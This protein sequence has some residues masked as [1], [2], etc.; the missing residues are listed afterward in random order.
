VSAEL[1]EVV[2]EL[3]R[4]LR[5]VVLPAL[6]A[7]AGRAH[8]GGG[9][10]AGDVTFAIDERAEAEVERTVAERAPHVA[11]Y[12]EDRGLTMPSGRAPEHVLIVDPIDGTRP[13]M[14]GFEAACVSVAVAPFGDGAPTM[15]DVELGVVVEIKSGAAFVARRGGGLEA[16]AE[17]GPSDNVDL[18]RLFWVYGLRGRPA[19][20]YGELLSELLDG[21]SVGGGC[22]DLGAATFDMTRV[23]TGQLDAYVEPGPLLI[24]RVPDALAEFERVGGGSVLNNAPYDLAAA[25]LC[26][27]EAGAIVTDAAGRALDPRPLLGSGHEFQM[28]VIAAGNEEL[29]AAL[30][31]AVAAGIE[32]AGRMVGPAQ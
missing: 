6:G 20:L 12:T 5:D 23:A 16:D 10:G 19:R 29:H 17:I 14:A 31:E 18:E 15:G 32:R 4:R 11:V 2:V 26:V 1:E 22:F 13:A 9:A 25:A 30:V 27:R 28:S 3:A 21:S 8:V 24:E 7:H